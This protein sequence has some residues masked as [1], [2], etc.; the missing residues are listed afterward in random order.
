M[1]TVLPVLV[2]ALLTAC[3]SGP[4]LEYL[5]TRSSENLELPPDLTIT[6]LNEKF[7]MPD[8]ISSGTGE[9]VGKIPVLAQVDSLRLEGSADYYWLAVDGPVDN[10]YKLIK[11]FWASEGYTLEVDE[12]VTGIM[13]TNWLLTE[14]GSDNEDEGFFESL[15]GSDLLF[16]VQDQYRTRIA[17]NSGTNSTRI[18]ISHRG[19]ETFQ[20]LETRSDKTQ[21]D[22]K[23]LSENSASE[24]QTWG[25]RP[26][27]PELEVEMLSRLM[28]FLGLKKAEVDQQL[29]NVKLFSPR[30]SIH[31]D[32]SDN[33]T[34]L[35]M[36]SVKELAWNRLL[37]ELDRL[38]IEVTSAEKSSGILGDGVIFVNTPYQIEVESGFFSTDTKLV[39]KQVAIVV[40]EETHKLTRISI[41]TPEGEIDESSEGV[42]FLTK[43]YENLR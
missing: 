38:D 26:R 30:A 34:Y 21:S 40:A 2:V 13:Q 22:F 14:A 16:A 42:E 19:T 8:N 3:S 25:F 28:V 41:E 35:L 37:H 29:A 27:E 24:P 15:F 18:H 20:Q 1:K 11:E 32:N 10:L 9:T 36:K 12:P 43:L 6:A 39:T 7:V 4:D 5:E 33:E 31:T 17:K 23:R